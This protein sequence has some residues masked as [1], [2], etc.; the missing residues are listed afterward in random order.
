MSS[1]AVTP[2]C[3]NKPSAVD[4]HREILAVDQPSGGHHA[5]RLVAG[6]SRFWSNGVGDAEQRDHLLALPLPRK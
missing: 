6:H 3:R 1:V 4:Q 5:Q 2:R